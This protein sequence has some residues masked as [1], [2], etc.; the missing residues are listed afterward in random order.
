[1]TVS[2]VQ[3]TKDGSLLWSLAFRSFFLMAGLWSVIALL[4]WIIVFS[5]D[6]DLPSRF[7]PLS[8]HIHEM[9]F[10]FVLAAIA[11]FLLT[12]IPNWTGRPPIRG[13]A[14]AG[15]AALWLAGRIICLV[16][17]FVPF[18][19]APIVDLAFPFALFAM[20]L[21]ELI[22]AR[23]WRNLAVP[24]PVAVLG[25]ADL[26]MHLESAGY[27]IPDGLGWRVGLAAVIIL[28]SVI[29]GRIIPA[30][31][32]NWLIGRGAGVK[33]PQTRGLIER[34]ALGCLHAGLI[35]WAIFPTSRIVGM[36]LVL[37]AVFNLV[38]LFGWQG[39]RTCAEPLLAILHVGYFWILAGAAMLG[40]GLLTS[41][42]PVTAAIHAFTAG[43]I[44]TM[45]VAVMTRVTLGHTGRKL[46]A[47]R[48]TTFLYMLVSAGAILRVAA[49]F[50]PADGLVLIV[51]SGVVWSGGFLLFVLRYGRMLLTKRI[52]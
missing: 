29:G 15:L 8:W 38:R 37:A 11:G 36:L 40:I 50:V 1:M 17:A 10:G 39:F 27:P 18:W 9:L 34:L 45:I 3:T 44:G 26:L 49:A 2:I 13:I 33:L 31:T 42:I 20:A 25:V 32:R 5:Q 6:I 7:D 52:D 35:A 21:H 46:V 4:L 24:A 30:F 28:I 16:S 22:A 51:I 19:L 14:L 41:A 48:I 47:D 43:A 12:A 23:N